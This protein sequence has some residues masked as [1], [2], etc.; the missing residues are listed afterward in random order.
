M[1]FILLLIY[2]AFFSI[3]SSNAKEEIPDQRRERSEKA[4]TGFCSLS[5]LHRKFV[6]INAKSTG[7]LK[8]QESE[9]Y[10]PSKHSKSRQSPGKL[11]WGG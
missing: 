9:P 11:V 5:D 10:N 8:P 3:Y 1:K 6:T 4:H 2:R 7:S